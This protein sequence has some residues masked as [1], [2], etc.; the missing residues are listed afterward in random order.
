MII[1]M[2]YTFMV[3]NMFWSSKFASKETLFRG[4]T[5][6]NPWNLRLQIINILVLKINF[7][8]HKTYKVHFDY[9]ILYVFWVKR[10]KKIVRR[11]R[12]EWK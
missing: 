12:T 11:R 2:V 1:T 7:L 3:K 10:I 5:V 8:P 9:V 4:R 6:R